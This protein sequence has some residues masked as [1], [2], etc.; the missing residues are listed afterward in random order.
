MLC[1][2]LLQSIDFE[3]MSSDVEIVETRLLNAYML[4]KLYTKAEAH[5]RI[6]RYLSENTKSN[7]YIKDLLDKIAHEPNLSNNNIQNYV[8]FIYQY[9]G[10]ALMESKLFERAT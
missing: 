9:L 6:V 3:M 10:D 7:L 2:K 1:E 5:E 4:M 8:L